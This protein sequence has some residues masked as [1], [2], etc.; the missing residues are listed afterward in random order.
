MERNR[1]DPNSYG[2]SFI[3]FISLYMNLSFNQEDARIKTLH[4]E[5]E[6]W[7][8]ICNFNSSRILFFFF[9]LL[10]LFF[11][12]SPSPRQILINLSIESWP[13]WTQRDTLS[14]TYLGTLI[15]WRFGLILQCLFHDQKRKKGQKQNEDAKVNH[16]QSLPFCILFF[17][18]F[19]LWNKH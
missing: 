3:K 5:N 18:F 11:N 12:S 16:E 6:I 13:H 7:S 9:L 1:E 8:F 10:L 19:L 2:L 4:K 14:S 17:F 15:G